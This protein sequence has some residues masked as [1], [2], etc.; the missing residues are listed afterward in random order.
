VEELNS[1]FDKPNYGGPLDPLILD[2]SDLELDYGNM[3]T[4]IEQAFADFKTDVYAKMVAL[5]EDYLNN[6]MVEDILLA[7]LIHQERNEDLD[8]WI[9]LSEWP[10]CLQESLEYYEAIENYEECIRVKA[11][12]DLYNTK[13]PKLN[14]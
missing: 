4:L 3:D 14:F 12:Q 5:I 2:I 7:I 8:V 1:Q 10:T 6:N 9:E 11:L 13:H